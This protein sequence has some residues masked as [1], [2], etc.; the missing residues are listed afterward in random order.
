M[1]ELLK[2]AEMGDTD[3]M[4]ALGRGFQFAK[5]EERPDYEK[6]FYWYEKAAQLKHIEAMSSLAD[7]LTLGRGCK[8]DS[9]M[10]HVWYQEAYEIGRVKNRR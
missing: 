10:A 5:F 7:A 3:A 4:Y 9:E 1:E 2:Q 8:K 6:A